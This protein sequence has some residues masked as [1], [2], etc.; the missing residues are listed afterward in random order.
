MGR[1]TV[2][3]AEIFDQPKETLFDDFSARTVVEFP[4]DI[5]KLLVTQL[6][7][8]LFISHWE[9]GYHDVKERSS[10]N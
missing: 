3:S 2:F 4:I 6:S 10:Q 8:E 9:D 5:P 7:Q 1:I